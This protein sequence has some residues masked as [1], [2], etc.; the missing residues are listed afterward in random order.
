MLVDAE[1]MMMQLSTGKR[2]DSVPPA[3]MA[4]FR[5]SVQPYLRSWFGYD[6]AVE[7]QKLGVPVLIAQGTT[8]IQVGSFGGALAGEDL[9]R[10]A[11]DHRR[12]ESRAE[13]RADRSERAD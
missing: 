1:R 9:S 7:M 2:I 6:P 8:D 3:L 13:A 12:H 10:H 5:P 11:R 4:L